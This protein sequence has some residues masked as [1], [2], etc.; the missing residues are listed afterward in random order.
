MEKNMGKVVN[1][2]HT[3]NLR[4]ERKFVYQDMYP[5]DLIAL[6]VL[7]NS[8]CFR[9]I[10]HRR[11]VNNCYFDDA[12]MSCYHQNVAGD[13]KRDKYRLRWYGD[14]FSQIVNPIFEIKKKHGT[15][16][17]KLSFP[18]K[19]LKIKLDTASSQ[20]LLKATKEAAK[21]NNFLALSI[22]IDLLRP[23]LYNSYERR[24]FL[25]H[26]KKFRITVDY[27]MLFY[28]PLANKYTMTKRAFKDIV[29]ELKYT[30]NDDKEARLLTQELSARLTKHSK[31]VRG[32]DA[33]NHLQYI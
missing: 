2:I 6:E 23:S 17:D 14:D 1:N 5:E 24:Y 25:S 29:L 32:V 4:Y 27:N 11:T 26:C 19:N 9:E 21:K 12:G 15:V 30:T 13:E 20:D 28:N 10:F 31:Y 22:A 7:T 33:I 8:F 18:F 3:Q 16:G